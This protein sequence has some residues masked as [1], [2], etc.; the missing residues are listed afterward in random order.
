MPVTH[1][2]PLQRSMMEG[3]FLVQRRTEEG[4]LVRMQSRAAGAGQL[5]LGQPFL[6]GFSLGDPDHFLS[7]LAVDSLCAEFLCCSSTHFPR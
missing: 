3:Y 1:S 6:I 5:S 2:L 4:E 7:G